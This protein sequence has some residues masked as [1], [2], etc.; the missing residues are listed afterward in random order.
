MSI[1]SI[2]RFRSCKLYTQGVDILILTY[3]ISI[4]PIDAT[5]NETPKRQLCIVSKYIVNI[6]LISVLCFQVR[7]IPMD[8]VQDSG[9]SD[10]SDSGS[11]TVRL[12]FSELYI[13]LLCCIMKK[14]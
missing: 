1:C 8:Q 7:N 9:G 11:S 12:A 6:H 4:V 13:I 5:L 10:S 3:T 2:H 14:G